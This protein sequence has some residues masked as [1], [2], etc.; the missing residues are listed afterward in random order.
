MRTPLIMVLAAITLL[1][2]FNPDMD[3]FKAFVHT[4]SARILLD[5]TGDTTLGRVLSGAG[6][7]LAGAYVDRVTDREN[8]FLFSTYHI[9]LDGPDRDENDWWFLGIGTRFIQLSQPESAK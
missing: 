6:S 4:E 9:D 8:Y 3:D 2:I 7:S 5:K 1:F